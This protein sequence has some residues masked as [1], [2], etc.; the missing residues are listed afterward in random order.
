MFVCMHRQTRTRALSKAW[1]VRLQRPSIIKPLTWASTRLHTR[2]S[3]RPINWRAVLLRSASVNVLFV[4]FFVNFVVIVFYSN[5][6]APVP[7]PFL[8]I[9]PYRSGLKKSKMSRTVTVTFNILTSIG[10]KNQKRVFAL[11]SA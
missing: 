1:R 10:W 2:I 5:S 11:E 8:L 6:F 7:F 4:F 9:F 3:P